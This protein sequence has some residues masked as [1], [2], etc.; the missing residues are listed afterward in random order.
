M[1]KSH[2]FHSIPS[3]SQPKWVTSQCQTNHEKNHCSCISCH[4]LS[5][6]RSREREGQK[7][8]EGR[9]HIRGNQWHWAFMQC[10]VRVRTVERNVSY[11]G[12][13]IQFWGKKSQCRKNRCFS[14]SIDSFRRTKFHRVHHN[15]WLIWEEAHQ[16]LLRV[17]ANQTIKIKLAGEVVEAAK[18]SPSLQ[19][20]ALEWQSVGSA[21]ADRALTQV[22]CAVGQ[23][24]RGQTCCIAK[25][26]ERNLED[27]S[28]SWNTDMGCVQKEKVLWFMQFRRVAYRCFDMK[29]FR[30]G[31]RT[32]E[33]SWKVF[34]FEGLRLC[35]YF[36]PCFYQASPAEQILA[37]IFKV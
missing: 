23:G 15:H 31:L 36:W 29:S 5:I 2:Q 4:S 22:I 30:M 32:L 8:P 11:T 28:Q 7:Y 10:C 16:L 33:T 35:Q 26:K 21:G 25:S 24:N 18:M 34:N 17:K 12:L 20:R 1:Q 37:W 9:I 14:E 3:M 6:S 27:D 19:D 13:Q